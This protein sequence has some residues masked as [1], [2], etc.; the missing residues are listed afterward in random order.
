MRAVEEGLPLVRAANTGISAVVDAYGRTQV[1]LELGTPGIIDT[2]LRRP[3]PP[4]PY[5][6]F[7]DGTA[8]ALV[9]LAWAVVELRPRL[10]KP[11]FLARISTLLH[12]FL[13]PLD[14]SGVISSPER[15][16]ANGL[17]DCSMGPASRLRSV[18][19]ARCWGSPW[20]DFSASSDRQNIAGGQKIHANI[21]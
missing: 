18:F 17:I 13:G 9:L 4:T 21:A 15:V 5:A 1:L 16:A 2:R 7:G 12:Y 3:L 14:S 10:Q 11:A 6:R 20:G 8:L 19:S